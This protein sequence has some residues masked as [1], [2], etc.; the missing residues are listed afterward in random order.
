MI[1]SDSP[2]DEVDWVSI[3]ERT[4]IGET[5][6]NQPSIGSRV[7]GTSECERREYLVPTQVLVA[8]TQALAAFGLSLSPTTDAIEVQVEPNILPPA[9][10]RRGDGTI[11]TP[12]RTGD[13][14]TY[15]PRPTRA[16]TNA[17]TAAPTH[18]PTRVPSRASTTST[19]TPPPTR[20]P[21]CCKAKGGECT[22]HFAQVRCN[23]TRLTTSCGT[24]HYSKGVVGATDCEMHDADDNLGHGWVTPA[25]TIPPTYDS[26]AASYAYYCAEGG[27]CD[28]FSVAVAMTTC[29][30]AK[31]EWVPRSHATKTCVLEGTAVESQWVVDLCHQVAERRGKSFTSPT[32]PLHDRAECLL[33]DGKY[34][35]TIRLANSLGV[36]VCVRQKLA[37][38]PAISAQR[39]TVAGRTMGVCRASAGVGG[40]VEA[41]GIGDFVSSV[42]FI[43]T[44]DRCPV[45][46]QVVGVICKSAAAAFRL[47]YREELHLDGDEPCGLTQDGLFASVGATM[48][49]PAPSA[50]HFVKILAF[51]IAPQQASKRG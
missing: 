46:A 50:Q 5:S 9:C 48:A 13:F 36:A 24:Y 33:L 12:R 29:T 37:R 23:I 10:H 40:L 28:A 30:T 27:V 15:E 7:K 14:A 49:A 42:F 26:E 44:T 35:V 2:C 32:L 8:C 45:G 21:S 19:P 17:P 39:A 34:V 43:P 18:A 41:P 25:P 47:P 16:P 11:V 22:W 6:A 31:G 20:N 3:G 38:V 1:P 4:C 51:G